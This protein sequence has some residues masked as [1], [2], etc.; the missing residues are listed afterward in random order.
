MTQAYTF[1]LD[2]TPQQRRAFVSH[3]GA[4]RYAYNWGL[5]RTAGALDARAAEV[6]AGGE[7]VTSLPSHFEL[8]KAWTVFKNDPANELGWVGQNFA[9]TYQAA[10]RD[11]AG[12]WRNFFASRNGQHK[13]RRVGR[14]RFRSKRR[15]RLAFQVH[16]D[17]FR[18]RDAHHV[19]LPKI[20]AVKTHESTRK[21][22]RRLT[23][24]TAR[25][26][27][28][29]VTRDAGGRWHVALTVQVQRPVR[30]TPSARQLAGGTVGVDL[31]VR[32]L[33][34]LSDGTVVPNPR[35]LG[36]AARKLARAGRAHARTQPGSRRRAKAKA[37]LGKMHARIGNL[38]LDASHQAT[39]R[40]V[41]GYQRI[42]V[43]G[44]NAQQLARSRRDVPRRV[45]RDRNRRLADAAL[46]RLRTQLRTKA[47]WYGSAVQIVDAHAPTGRTC[48]VC[49]AVRTTPI[50][51]RQEL[52][53]CPA[54][55]QLDR[56]VN[57]AR[58]LV[59][60]SSAEETVNARGPG[61]SPEAAGQPGTKREARTRP[62]PSPGVEVGRAARTR[63]GLAP[64]P[65]DDGMSPKP[66]PTSSAEPD[67]AL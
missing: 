64:P 43:E 8:C 10:L 42:V 15:T 31:G 16:G 48:S 26:V 17:G 51:P 2:P 39:T 33:M 58:L 46:G 34:T 62:D 9:G 18:V 44:W 59:V 6:A 61:V 63:K 13:G 29:T 57:T 40:L 38:R 66:T 27:R 4:A 21:V 56:R 28:G 36:A 37:R 67:A 20:G 52:F 45:R 30:T 5:A 35:P 25:L 32:D 50:P 53:T 12:A 11:A 55:H 60:A 47:A 19:Q 41:H 65:G 7:P 3:A 49:G 23:A 24:G 1:A 14:P 54:G 22:L